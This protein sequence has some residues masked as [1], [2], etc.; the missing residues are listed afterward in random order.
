[1]TRAR[2][3]GGRSN[4]NILQSIS[5][6][7]RTMPKWAQWVTY[8]S[9][10][11][12]IIGGLSGCTP[13][14]ITESLPP[15]LKKPT[16]TPDVATPIPTEVVIP[17]A[18]ATESS[19]FKELAQIR[20]LVVKAAN[21][22]PNLS[23][24]ESDNTNL[25]SEQQQLVKSFEDAQ[26]KITES[27]GA[28]VAKMQV[29]QAQGV[30]SN[31]QFTVGFST[32]SFINNGVETGQ[33]II[34]LY[35][36]ANGDIQSFPISV[37]K[38]SE[39]VDGKVINRYPVAPSTQGQLGFNG[40]ITVS[41]SKD[42]KEP[43]EI[44]VMQPDGNGNFIVL[45]IK[46]LGGNIEAKVGVAGGKAKLF[47]IKEVKATKTPI[48]PSTPIPETIPLPSLPPEALTWVETQQAIDPEFVL[49]GQ[50]DAG[51][52]HVDLGDGKRIDVPADQIAARIKVGQEG[53]LQVYSET[54][55]KI[56]AAYD[57]E[58]KAWI[59]RDNVIQSDMNNMENYIHVSTW[60]DLQELFRLEKHFMIPFPEDTYFPTFDETNVD[61]LTRKHVQGINESPLGNPPIG[62]EP[63][64]LFNYYFL[65]KG[66]GREIDYA[67]VT[68]QIFNPSDKT[69]SSSHFS[70]SAERFQSI[71][72][73]GLRSGRAYILPLYQLTEDDNLESLKS[74]YPFIF[75]MWKVA[76]LY[77]G[78]NSH[79]FTKI[80]ELVMKWL[81]EKKFPLPLEN[82]PLLG[83]IQ[84]YH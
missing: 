8:G 27:I 34:F 5:A 15:W 71:V 18:M 39:V 55:D 79:E 42:S 63:T 64:R 45:A 72:L 49:P 22:N 52:F 47:N 35:R 48:P 80:K 6:T 54:G 28:R 51:G 17:T 65:E 57:P 84:T 62:K 11:A 50:L 43:S 9:A 37:F 70:R 20:D 24:L 66:E 38:N 3:E 76:G 36:D 68:E 23:V 26:N 77:D 31:T 69:F 32:L 78:G 73:P 44:Y 30:E 10:A 82:T 58:S 21:Q 74:K 25:S 14:Q 1:M 61:Y 81:I 40:I 41:D 16:K 2:R 56:I 12:G 13:K 46:G 19:Q 59:D 75:D 67:G 83:Y 53:A 60:A 7:V 4:P 33:T 29:I